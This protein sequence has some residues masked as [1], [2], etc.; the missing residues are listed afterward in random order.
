[1]LSLDPE[2]PRDEPQP[3]GKCRQLQMMEL[4]GVGW[5]RMGWDGNT[6]VYEGQKRRM[7]GRVLIRIMHAVRSFSE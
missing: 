2:C 5:S 6:M 3:M 1:M 4:D 7:A